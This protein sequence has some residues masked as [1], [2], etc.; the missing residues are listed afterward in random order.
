MVAGADCGQQNIAEQPTDAQ[1]PA[2]KSIFTVGPMQCW[3]MLQEHHT[4][5]A[6]LEH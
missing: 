3:L 2:N 6:I 5:L 1:P 4:P